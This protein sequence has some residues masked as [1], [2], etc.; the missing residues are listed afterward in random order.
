ML[1]ADFFRDL[2]N[3]DPVRSLLRWLDDPQR[4]PRLGS[5]TPSGRRSCSN[6]R[7]TTASIRPSTARSP[8]AA[9]SGARKGRWA[10]VWKRFAETPERYPGIPDQ[11]RKARPEELIVE[12]RRRLAAGQRDG[13]RPAPQPAARL[14]GAHAR[15]RSQGGGRGSTP[16]TPGVAARSGPTSTWRRSRSRSSSSSL[17]AELDAQHRSPRMTSRRSSPTTPSAA[18][19]PTTPC[20]ERWPRPTSAPTG[21]RCP[22]PRRRCTG[23]GSTPGPRRS[24]RR[25]ARWRT[26]TPTSPAR[27]RRRRQARSPCS[28]TGCAS[29]SPIACRS[30]SPASGSTCRSTTSLAA[31]PDGHPDRQAGARPHRRGRARRRA[32]TSIRRTSATGTKASIQ[33]LRVAHGRQRRAGPRPDR[34]RRSRRARRGPRPV[35]STIGATTSAIRLVDHLDEEVGRIVEP[36]PRAARRRLA[37]GRR[38]HRPRVDASA[39]RH[40]EG[41]AARRR[42]PRSR[43]AGAHG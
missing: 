2:V 5:T 12:D 24:R 35:S 27:R 39:G 7:P 11:L 37:A 29:T 25:S 6:A 40:G 38:R 20:C 36:H 8:P 33:V 34:D 42:R 15:G 28:S 9:S 23:R 30:G 16:S 41:R 14:R 31:L 17:L 3:P 13:R 19:G 22:R 21:P 26:R 43:R 4:L 1:D 18:G 10:N 32:R